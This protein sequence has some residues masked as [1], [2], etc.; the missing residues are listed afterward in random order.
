MEEPIIKVTIIDEFKTI[1]NEI[2]Q[3]SQ[4]KLNR[5]IAKTAVLS[6]GNVRN[7]VLPEKG[8][9]E[10]A[11]IIKRFEYSPL[12]GVLKKQTDIAKDHYMFLKDQINVNNNDREDGVKTEDGEEI[13]NVHMR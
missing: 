1:N 3:K 2:K 6:S 10:K 9:L 5:Q 13:D 8:L 11:S 7:F 4:Y 12:G